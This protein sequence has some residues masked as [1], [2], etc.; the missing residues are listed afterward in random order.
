[1]AVLEEAV[2]CFQEYVLATRPR[3]QSQEAEEWILEK[4]SEYLFSFENIRETLKL[5]PYYIRQ[6]LLC[7]KDAKLKL[8][9]Y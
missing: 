6:G 3:E 9:F 5:H 8:S 4:D 1:M 7:W 2:K